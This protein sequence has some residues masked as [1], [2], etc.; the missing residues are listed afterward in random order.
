MIE[1]V[2]QTQ[3]PNRAI[4][5]GKQTVS[6][7]VGQQIV[8]EQAALALRLL[9]RAYLRIE[10]D[11][12]DQVDGLSLMF[13]DIG[14]EVTFV[15]SGTSFKAGAVSINGTRLVL[16]PK[17]E[18]VRMAT[19][20]TTRL[21]KLVLHLFNF[22]A[23]LCVGSPKMDLL[24]EDGKGGSLSTEPLVNALKDI[25]GYAITHLGQL[26]RQDSSFFAPVE[27][28]EIV[29]C[30]H[31]FLS[32][33]CGRNV[34]PGLAVGFGEDG[35]RLW[36][37][38]GTGQLDPWAANP[39]SWFD[40]QHG[41]LLAQVFP[42]FCKLWK[43]TRWSKTIKT[44]IYWYLRSNRAGAGAGVDGGV[45]LSQAA[46][47]RLAW[48]YAVKVHRMLSGVGF[49]KLR[50]SDKL[51]ILLTSLG[52]PKEIPPQLTVITKLAGELRW[53]DGPQ[54]LTEVR[55]Y[56][57]HPSEKYEGKFSG[58]YAEAWNLAQWYLDLVLLRLCNHN[59]DYGN[60]ITQEWTGQVESVPWAKPRLSEA[61][62]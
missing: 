51:R 25:G 2:Y 62:L 7:S 31:F 3:E 9:P 49:D 40:R 41:E 6:F 11:V 16:A 12:G 37:E 46:L 45:I 47:E 59:G 30:L 26:Q 18:P 20:E 57:V 29:T 56:L 58:V 4:E 36:Q 15:E 23:F 17:S 27:A 35:Q 5:L 48:V 38:W 54:A 39:G 60:R 10:L 33:A 42:G 52:L 53:E 44:A 43:D 28:E 13:E 19:P 22:P 32:F 50:A 24:L 8:C 1:A 34:V 21:N 14:D 55:N 61:I